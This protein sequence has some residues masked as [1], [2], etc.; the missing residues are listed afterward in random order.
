MKILLLTHSFNSLTQRF[1]VE[2]K[3]MGHNISVEFDIND[4]VTQEA[5]EL[6]NPDLI[7]AP[8]LK[9]KISQS[10]W[11]TVLTIIVHPGVRG[12]R[13]PSALDWAILNGEKKWG[14]TFIE[15]SN[16]LDGGAVWAWEEFPMR[17]APKSSTYRNEVTEASVKCLHTLLK[18]VGN[19]NSTPELISNSNKVN[20]K[21]NPKMT[22]S[23]RAINWSS[24]TTDEVL[25]RIHCSDGFPGVK[26]T[27]FDENYFLYNTQIEPTLKGKPGDIIAVSENSICRATVDGA[28]WIG[29][30][31]KAKKNNHTYLKLPATKVLSEKL[32]NIPHIDSNIVSDISTEITQGIAIIRFPFYNGAMST[33]QCNQLRC[34]VEEVKEKSPKIIVLMGGEEFWSN[35]LH[36]HKIENSQSPSHASFENIEAMND[37][38]LRLINTPN[39]WVISA[40]KGNAG[41]GGVFLALAGDTVL[42][43]DGVVLN[44]HYKSMGNLYGSEYWT[45]LLPKKVGNEHSVKITDNR[46]P[47]SAK[48]SKKL[49]L[50]DKVF[51]CSKEDFESHVLFYAKELLQNQNIDTLIK[52]KQ[53]QREKDEAKKRLVSYR[54]EELEKMRLNFFGFDPS[55]HVARYNFVYK[56]PISR[57]PLHLAI[58]RKINR[59]DS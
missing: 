49:G 48:S 7:L 58:H 40:I 41:A 35:G 29:H 5:V 14:V 53:T 8:Y 25:K 32:K 50:V 46:L 27:L 21:Y 39:S 17:V 1:Y 28:V 52:D 4:E 33:T 20:G 36:L 22:Q 51:N 3:D 30:L 19:K 57:T 45:Y 13:G 55:Y 10:I 38:V 54:E 16:E 37:I 26:D 56:R 15:A 59:K 24:H 6:F 11:K 18:C 34:A 47:I 9:R 31:K 42:I 44:P 43:R 12:D 23:D 2:L